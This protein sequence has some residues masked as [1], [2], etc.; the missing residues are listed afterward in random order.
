MLFRSAVDHMM[1]KGEG[2]G[3]VRRLH[4]HHHPVPARDQQHRQLQQQQQQQHRQ[5]QIP[6]RYKTNHYLFYS[7][8]SLVRVYVLHKQE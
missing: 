4:H 3:G 1:R 5:Q 8:L 7:G 6:T 2:A